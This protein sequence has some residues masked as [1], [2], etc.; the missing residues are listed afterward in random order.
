VPSTGYFPPG[1][2]PEGYFPPGYFPGGSSSSSPGG[3]GGYFPP[4]MFP[5]DY[6]PADYFPVTTGEVVVVPYDLLE[7][8]VQWLRTYCASSLPGGVHTGLCPPDSARLGAYAELMEVGE[9]FFRL[10][11]GSKVHKGLLQI[12][13]YAN[14]RAT[15]KRAGDAVR[16]SLFDAHLTFETG[17]I[18]S[19]DD[20]APRRMLDERTPGIGGANLFRDISQFVYETTS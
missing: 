2:F 3:S 11:A 12:D 19:I 18:L 14:S 10:S 4:G 9:T 5:A 1:Y 16:T 20:A 6:F 7:S 8:A 15:A 13:V 17:R